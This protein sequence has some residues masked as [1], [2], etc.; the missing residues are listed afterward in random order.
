MFKLLIII[1]L[2]SLNLQALESMSSH[3]IDKLEKD[4]NKMGKEVF[5]LKQII[6]DNINVDIFTLLKKY[7]SNENAFILKEWFELSLQRE[8]NKNLT[9]FI[10]TSKI[11]IL[12]FL[13]KML[14]D[15]ETKDYKDIKKIINKINVTNIK[16][17]ASSYRIYKTTTDLNIRKMPI[18]SELTKDVHLI[19]KSNKALYFGAVML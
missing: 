2:L 3:D 16:Y 10:E 8:D 4:V 14:F 7:K 13:E 11:K 1:F 17:E 19:L 5:D 12:F 18:L 6:E 9:Y 15:M